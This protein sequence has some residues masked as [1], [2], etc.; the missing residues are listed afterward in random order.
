VALKSGSVG[1]GSKD[2]FFINVP[3][4]IKIIPV[5]IEIDILY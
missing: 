2:D 5:N 3:A 1:Q 4:I